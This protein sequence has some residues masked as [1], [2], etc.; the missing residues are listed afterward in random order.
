[1]YENANIEVIARGV[2][3]QNDHLLLCRGKSSEFCYL[4]GGH[5]E[6]RETARHALIREISE[7]MGLEAQVGTFLGCC[8]HS[9]LQKKVP[10]TEINLVF[11]L[12]IPELKTGIPPPSREAWISFFWHPLADLHELKAEPQ[13]LFKIIQKT[14]LSA[15]GHLVTGDEWSFHS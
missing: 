10:H 3:L 15:W 4:P 8:E 7:E 6:F 1:M 5:V 9:F 12:L 11:T 14:P 13:G 2:M